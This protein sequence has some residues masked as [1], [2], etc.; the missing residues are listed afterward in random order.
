MRGSFKNW[1][2]VTSHVLILN[3]RYKRL[4]GKKTSVNRDKPYS[5]SDSEL[6]SG[7]DSG[8]PKKNWTRTQG[9]VLEAS[10]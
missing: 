5:D 4:K 7:C 1:Y 9:G 8:L 6:R 2:N 3:I 10:I